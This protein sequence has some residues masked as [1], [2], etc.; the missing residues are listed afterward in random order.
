[1]LKELSVSILAATTLFSASSGAV[2]A[3]PLQ[4][5][6]VEAKAGSQAA[7]STVMAKIEW[8]EVPGAAWYEISIRDL[9]T[10]WK[11]IGRNTSPDD[12]KYRT[13]VKKGN[14]FK[15]WVGAFDKK[16]VLLKQDSTTKRMNRDSSIYLEL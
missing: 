2:L 5:P 6:A 14:E 11:T 3:E 10:N 8:D 16:G 15:F 1:M 4:A 13:Y 7:E 12:T 9:D